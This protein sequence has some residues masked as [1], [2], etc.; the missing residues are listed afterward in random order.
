M[1]LAGVGMATLQMT[2]TN[3]TCA[4]A[5]VVGRR[6][7]SGAANANRCV[8]AGRETTSKVRKVHTYV[9]DRVLASGCN[10]HVF[11]ARVWCEWRF[12]L[13]PSVVT[14]LSI[15]RVAVYCPRRLRFHTCARH[16]AR[17]NFAT[18]GVHAY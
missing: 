2:T 7:S 4:P 1:P 3:I 14:C 6:A 13:F 10:H 8:R 18:A 11:A 15:P 12:V 16:I 9:K 17:Q 5:A